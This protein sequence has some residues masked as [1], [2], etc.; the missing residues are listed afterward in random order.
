LIAGI[1]FRN[2]KLVAGIGFRNLKLVA[3]IGFSLRN[4]KSVAGV[5][6]GIL[7]VGIDGI[8]GPL[9]HGMPE[10]FFV[11]WVWSRVCC[12]GQVMLRCAVL[13]VVLGRRGA[14][15]GA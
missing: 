8:Q 10:A 1:G 12:P 2:L 11:W 13:C 3:G 5:G 6:F 4:L 9:G 15:D 7:K 14:T